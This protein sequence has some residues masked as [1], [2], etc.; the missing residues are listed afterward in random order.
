MAGPILSRRTFLSASLAAGGGLLIGLPFGS[1]VAATEPAPVPR[2]FIRIGTDNTITLILPYVEMGQGAYT[3][4]VQILAEELEVDPTQVAYEAAPADEQLYASPLF[5]GQITGGSGSLRGAWRTMRSAG[6]AARMMLIDAAARRWQVSASTCRVSD[7]RIVHADGRSLTYG[8][9]AEDA[10]RLPVPEAPILKEPSTYKVIGKP[11]RRLDTPMKING[12]AKFGIDARPAGVQHAVVGSC[13]VIN[14]TVNTVDA[15]DALKISGVRQ[16]IQLNDAVAV[17]ANTTW[18]AWKGL[19]ALR[20][21]WNDGENSTLTTQHMVD[22]ADA[23][24]EVAG[25]VSTATGDVLHA[26]AG[27]AGRYDAVFRLPLLAH[28]AMEPLNC[29]VD[30]R[31]DGCEIW[32]GSQVVGRAQKA[33]ADAAGLPLA[34]VV[35]HNHLLGGGFG[36][37]LETD[38]VTQAVLIARQIKGPIK[39]TWSREEDIRQD[40][41]RYHNHSRVSV[42]LGVRG[43]PVSWRHKV[44]GPNIM[45]RFLPV[46]Q[47]D[48]VDLDIVDDASGPYDIPNIHIE[49][50]RNEAPGGLRTGNWRGVGPTRNVFI[51]ESV[52]DDLAHRAG[53]DPI[54][55]RRA[56]MTSGTTSRPRA[57][58]ELAVKEAGWGGP[59]PARHGRGA[60]VFS[61]FG[62]HLGMVAEVAVAK[63]GA[64]TVQRVVC[65]ID[66]G[67]IVNP[68]IVRA[69]IE[70]G[71]IFGISAALYG[72][73]T[74]AGGRI[75]QTNF[76]TYPVLRM[77]EAPRI[78]VHIMASQEE[79]GGVG[80]PGTAGVIAAVANAVFAATGHRALTLPLNPANLREA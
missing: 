54:D 4:Q 76:D 22:A 25:I 14:G 69:Q 31:T 13:P 1:F 47:K 27:A 38:Y 5:G 70:G 75:E 19:A 68:D 53:R 37:R 61:G 9:V 23:A 18:A 33:A 55:Y 39:V 6:A 7:R 10:A 28:A 66:A 80:E 32:V 49:Y 65:A 44:V 2:A 12:T 3:S 35:V 42:G 43:E 59:M 58:M 34:K 17:V 51:V 40:V 77:S 71:I 50:S 8:E 30:L 78:E 52:I 36:R 11:L 67:L 15:I 63:S 45:S 79:P 57:A 62:S 73:V 26:E 56:L 46:Y 74:I 60:A 48:G 21:T 24:L 16:V 29:T 64:I 72:R 20:V 41:F